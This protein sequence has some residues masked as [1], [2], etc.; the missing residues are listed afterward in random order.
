MRTRT[1][2]STPPETTRTAC[3][4]CSRWRDTSPNPR[5]GPSA[6]S[7]FVA[8][9]GHHSPGMNGPRSFVAMNP[10]LVASSVL[11]FNIEHVAQ[12]NL[13]RARSLFDDGYREYIADS[14]EAPIVAGITNRSPFLEDL[15][16][17]GVERY[18]INFV[19]GASTM[20]S[21]EGGGYR[22]LGVPIVTA[23]QAPPL[24][25]T[26]GEVLETI[27]TPGPGTHGA[28]SGVFRQRG[29]RCS[30]TGNRSVEGN[31]LG[32]SPTPST[33]SA[34]ETRS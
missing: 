8:S 14:G 33:T 20:A 5:T 24:Y 1:A 19:S 22:S 3:R 28:V 6:R 12:R 13:S 27:S 11:V 30:A 7:Y 4:Y 29:G 16:R 15:I 21:G 25:H 2:G 17:R 26:S 23:M 31:S 18:G 32:A 9:A 10:E 34:T